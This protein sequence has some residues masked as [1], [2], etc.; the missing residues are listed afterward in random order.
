MR[1]CFWE[2]GL[3]H[4]Q[5]PGT[6]HPPW[7]ELMLSQWQSKYD[8]TLTHPPLSLYPHASPP[9]LPCT[10]CPRRLTSRGWDPHPAKRCSDLSRSRSQ[11]YFQWLP[12]NHWTYLLIICV[13]AD[14]IP[15]IYLRFRKSM[16]VPLCPRGSQNYSRLEAASWQPGL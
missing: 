2:A 7:T 9:R 10:S 5:G 12:S 14:V 3:G 13:L 11:H 1:R 8:P 15:V 16:S 4:R 6:S